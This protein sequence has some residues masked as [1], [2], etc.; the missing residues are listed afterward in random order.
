MPK[1]I[2]LVKKDSLKDKS[3]LHNIRLKDKEKTIALKK[4]M[5][6]KR[7]RVNPEVGTAIIPFASRFAKHDPFL[8]AMFYGARGINP[9]VGVNFDVGVDEEFTDAMAEISDAIRNVKLTHDISPEFTEIVNNFMNTITSLQSSTHDVNIKTSLPKL[10]D[11]L[12]APSTMSIPVILSVVA[13]LIVAYYRG[14]TANGLLVGSIIGYLASSFGSVSGSLLTLVMDFGL[15]RN[16][17]KPEMSTEE[18][19]SMITGLCNTA[20]VTGTVTNVFDPQPLTAMFNNLSRVGT[21]VKPIVEVFAMLFSYIK[22]SISKYIYSDP[23]TFFRTGHDYLDTYLKEFQAIRLDYENKMLLNNDSSLDRVRSLILEGE[24]ICARLPGGRDSAIFKFRLNESLAKLELIKKTLL[25]SNFK[26][27]G[28]RQEPV[29]ILMRGPPGCGKSLTMQHLAHAIAA[30]TFSEEDYEKYKESSSVFVYNRQAENVYWEGYDSNKRI[31]FIDDICQA[32]DVVGQPDNE[33]MNVIRA[34]NVF[35]NQLHCASIESKGNT[36]FRSHFV[37]ANTNMFSM[38]FESIND[39]GAFMRRW[40]IVIDVCPKQEYCVDPEKAI[41]D[42]KMDTS[43]A[44][45]VDGASSLHPDML[46]FYLQKTED[47][48]FVNSNRI[49]DFKDLVNETCAVYEKKTKWHKT[50]LKTLEQTLLDNRNEVLDLEHVQPQIG[51]DVQPNVRLINFD[52]LTNEE[53][54]NLRLINPAC[55]SEM[56]GEFI[57]FVSMLDATYNVEVVKPMVDVFEKFMLEYYSPKNVHRGTKAITSFLTRET[58]R[59]T[60]EMAVKEA[61]FAIPYSDESEQMKITQRIVNEIKG[62]FENIKLPTRDGLFNILLKHY[63]SI[64]SY[65]PPEKCKPVLN[66]IDRNKLLLAGGLSSVLA[67]ITMFYS[68]RLPSEPILGHSNERH[69][70][71]KRM[72]VPKEVQRIAPQSI[73][74]VNS[75]LADLVQSIAKRNTLEFWVPVSKSTIDGEAVTKMSRY[76]FA[77]AVRGTTII[78]PYHFVSELAGSRYDDLAIDD[79]DFIELRK[80]YTTDVVFKFTVGEFFKTF[81]TDDEFE[82]QE[83]AYIKLPRHFP[84]VRDIV[85]N[86][87]S[88]KNLELYANI[89]AVLSIPFAVK[90]DKQCPE[91]CSVVARYNKNVVDVKDC[92]DFAPYTIAETWLYRAR[93]S[94]GDCGSVLFVDDSRKSPKIIGFH[95]AGVAE[96]KM[97]IS[98]VITK[99]MVE[100]ICSRV[101]ERYVYEDQLNLELTVVNDLPNKE[102]LGK[103]LPQYASMG[104]G[105]TK[106]IKSVLHG[107]WGEAVTAPARLRPFINERGERID[108]M[109][110]AN[111]RYCLNYSW[112]NPDDLF[113]AQVSLSDMLNSTS[114]NPVKK[115]IFSFKMAVLGDD[116]GIFK[117]IPRVTSAG[118]PYTTMKGCHTKERFFG[119]DDDYDLNLDECRK[120]EQEVNCVIEH[121]KKGIRLTHVFIDCLKD[122]RRPL[123]KVE[124]GD[125]RMF[126]ASPTPLLIAS[127]MYFGAFQKWIGANCIANGMAI[128]VNE[129]SSDW[130]YIARKIIGKNG[131]VGAGDFKSFDAR[132]MPSV[133]YCILDIINAW[134]GSDAEDNEVRRVI[135]YEIVNSMHLNR[136]IIYMWSSSLSS[137]H[138]LTILVNCLYNHMLF[139]LVWLR[140]KLP[141]EDFNEHVYLIV[142]GDDHV[143]SVTQYGASFFNERV[144]QEAMN[145]MGMTYTPEDKNKTICDESLRTIDQVTFLKRRFEWDSTIRRYV[146]PLELK[147]I[148][149]IP[150]WIKDG[151]STLGDT[152]NNLRICFEELSLHSKPVFQYWKERILD[153]LYDN[154]YINPPPNTNYT[155]LRRLV[156]A[157]E[158]GSSLTSEAYSY[159]LS[160]RLRGVVNEIDGENFDVTLVDGKPLDI[161]PYCQDG[162]CAVRTM[163]RI[164]HDLVGLIEPQV[165]TSIAA[166]NTTSKHIT[167]SDGQD[168]GSHSVM[169]ANE[170]STSS[171]PN[172]S[173]ADATNDGVTKETVVMKHIPL[174]NA[175]LDSANTGVTQEVAVFLSKPYLLSSGNFATTDSFATSNYFQSRIYHAVIT[176]NTI[177][178]NKV[179]GNYV[180][181]GT[182]VFTLFVNANRFQ[183][184]RYI[185]AWC[186][187][188]G[189]AQNSSIFVA[190]HSAKLTQVTQLPHVEIDLSM[191]TQAVLHVPFINATGWNPLTT[192]TPAL[193]DIGSLMLRA[194]SPLVS[195]AGSTTA[196]WSLYVHMED[197]KFKMPVV[198]Q[199]RGG[200]K[201]SV[202]KRRPPAEVEAAAGGPISS[203]MNK[204]S[205]V[206]GNLSSIP[207]LSSVAGPVSWASGIAASIASA[208]GWSKPAI[209]NPFIMIARYIFPKYNNADSHDTTFKLAVMD[210]NCVEDMVGFSGTDLDEMSLSYIASIPAW[211]STI[212]WTTAQAV[213]TAITSVTMSP[214]AYVQTSTYGANTVWFPAP[215]SY[216]A[217]FFSEYRGSLRLTVK[218][219]KTEFHSGRLA[220]SFYPFDYLTLGAAPGVPSLAQSEYLHREIIDIRNGNEFT[221]VIPYT[222]ILP[223]R[224]TFG[225]DAPYGTIFFHVL[226]PLIAPATVSS[227]VTLLFEISAAEDMEFAYPRTIQEQIVY[228]IVP[229][230]GKEVDQ[231]ALQFELNRIDYKV[232][233]LGEQIAQLDIRSRHFQNKLN[234]VDRPPTTLE[235]INLEYKLK[236]ISSTLNLI[237]ARF[238]NLVKK[239]RDLE[240]LDP[241][242]DDIPNLLNGVVPQIGDKVSEIV[243]TEIGNSQYHESLIPSRLCIGERVMSFRQLI[244]RYNTLTLLNSGATQVYFKA[245]PFTVFTN[246]ITAAN[247]LDAPEAFTDIYSIVCSCYALARGSIRYK[248]LDAGDP[249]NHLMGIRN[250]PLSLS[251]ASISS[252]NFSYTAISPTTFGGFGN[253]DNNSLTLTGITAGLEVDY[254]FYSRAFAYPIADVSNNLAVDLSYSYSS[255]APRTMMYITWDAAPQA[256]TFF[257]AAGEDFHAG[258]FVSVP[259]F[260]SWNNQVS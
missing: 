109:L 250:A 195:P 206:S 3:I 34:I 85:D 25:A 37:I 136:D 185:L 108:P 147:V 113:L 158:V 149:E 246:V 93:T 135:W 1:K 230:V 148:L 194:Y 229:Q 193:W 199:S 14:Y 41:W 243:S 137:G 96:S 225:N 260:L 198:P 101:D 51:E 231:D 224:P 124:R 156:L 131:G 244:K 13:A 22:Y 8:V 121:A 42:R 24:Y 48:N 58:L 26:F 55:Y 188:G 233:N 171:F 212:S 103:V 208:F 192:T 215:V 56:L 12:P 65:F 115:E 142:C 240:K 44:P 180:T 62:S 191:D 53:L 82:P 32:R 213:G 183:Q 126:S 164:H 68:C 127:R 227:T 43:K 128:S 61:L 5:E 17:V 105:K 9:Q 134:Y 184:G 20:L 64:M 123:K 116:S 69:M 177:W 189:A 178:Y 21:G 78:F 219:V 174:T 239:R 120:L 248:L 141:I 255:T 251:S 70:R 207:L 176:G 98:T 18:L 29:S 6:Y 182:L 118:F 95:V 46:E 114:S 159:D 160:T 245:L 97:G 88:R 45:V 7:E 72:R 157:R 60:T 197:V 73:Q 201:T 258:L 209:N 130:D 170:D 237:T 211:F 107:A 23:Y 54:L 36:T 86:F 104:S 100:K 140:F 143:Y 39:K 27:N 31:M 133:H 59:T 119:T 234:D 139:R 10:K 223:Y 52:L 241:S 205:T 204:V 190:G 2:T 186:P 90:N 154:P 11:L 259:G 79:S 57:F 253:G 102:A 49:L 168:L 28:I 99:E 235:K 150:Y 254:P 216:V 92:V 236:N 117:A 214:R 153:A 167:F 81:R 122:E 76:G 162:A 84:P 66:F 187:D 226:N 138:A 202:R 161:D 217:N 63:K 87:A 152:E 257:R 179:S 203:F 19:T 165:G 50:Y 80:F 210:S 247:A 91:I 232:R 30:R 75:N 74:A 220:M 256:T 222:S 172:Y 35:E 16:T 249:T 106:N 144:I 83:I 173:T 242:Y 228:P 40:D 218:L 145:D 15:D 111:L 110:D 146:A 71:S 221:F 181:R 169:S 175:H 129:Y 33:I 89:D 125:T 238:D 38:N 200:V 196:S 77:V 67:L 94:P 252:S 47:L 4:S 155:S 166:T 151:A 112:I 132:E 163:S